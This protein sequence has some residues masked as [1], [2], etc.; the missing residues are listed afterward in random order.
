MHG[1]DQHADRGALAIAFRQCHE[2]H[3]SH[4]AIGRS[5]VASAL[6]TP[7]A[8]DRRLVAAD[9]AQRIERAEDDV[10]ALVVERIEKRLAAVL[11]DATPRPG[12]HGFEPT[13]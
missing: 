11:L 1:E 12:T 4:A 3:A 7:S 10:H 9:V 5:A 6:L 13:P 8:R 2:T